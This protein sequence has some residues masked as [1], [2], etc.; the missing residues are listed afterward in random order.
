MLISI[1]N[2]SIFIHAESPK[3][4]AILLDFLVVIGT[5]VLSFDLR[6]NLLHLLALSFPLFLAHFEISSKEFLIWLPITS[7]QPIPQRGELSVVK[8]KV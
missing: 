7:T 1:N 8:V 4:V 6:L 2:F 3:H 5:V